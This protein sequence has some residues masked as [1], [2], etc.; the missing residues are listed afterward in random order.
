M[1]I[2]ASLL[3]WLAASQIGA[4]TLTFPSMKNSNTQCRLDF[5]AAVSSDIQHHNDEDAS[6]AATTSPKPHKRRERY[7]GRYPKNFKHKYKEMQG[8]EETVAKVL[9]KGM[10]PAGQHVPIMVRECLHYMGL[11]DNQPKSDPMLVVDCT[12]GYGGHSSYILKQIMNSTDARLIAFDQDSVEIR[13]TEERLRKSVLGQTAITADSSEEDTNIFTAVNQNFAELGEY[14]T[15]TNQVGK[16]TSLLAD[17]G[18]SSMQIDNNDRGFTYKRDGPL[19]MRMSADDTKETAYQLLQRLRV[20]QLKSMLKQNSDEE[21][22]AEIAFGLIG[23]RGKIPTTTME[24]ADRVRDIARPLIIKQHNWN[25]E[26][27]GKNQAKKLKTQLD[28]TIARVMQAIRIEVN[29]EFRVLEKL[30]EDIPTKVLS[31]GG[32]VVILTFHSGEDRRV[33]KSFKSGFQSG[34]YSV[35]GKDVV[36]PTKEERRNNPRSS[37]CKLRWAILSDQNANVMAEQ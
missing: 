30:L 18:L 26:Q 16:V 8:D 17:L 12:L 25:S 32:K 10:T 36:R 24:L 19:D 37:C 5:L 34:I 4:F 6:I 7:S 9:S 3:F 22:A 11:E 35:W 15:S 33:K 23:D 20:R 27:I 31:P 14:M 28:S 2:L 1:A 21:F 29:G 13:K